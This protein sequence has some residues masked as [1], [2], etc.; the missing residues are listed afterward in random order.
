MGIKKSANHL[1]DMPAGIAQRGISIM[2][3][4][5]LGLL[6]FFSLK[7][8]SAESSY[9][10]QD[11]EKI[12]AII[13]PAAY[14]CGMGNTDFVNILSELYY[15]LRFESVGH[16]TLGS[17]LKFYATLGEAKAH[18]GH[19]IPDDQLIAYTKKKSQKAIIELITEKGNI[20]TINA[21]Y[22]IT[23][24]KRFSKIV[25]H[26]DDSEFLPFHRPQW[27][28]NAI[29]DSDQT[30]GALAEINRQYMQRLR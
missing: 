23:K 15:F 19:E 12:Y 5:V 20:I 16:Y 26:D 14:Y 1:S 24:Y 28:K 2:N 22:S 18:F 30:L 8:V 10:E 7:S 25:D 6:L 13:Q 17:K 4:I 9:S 11:Q 21:I 27:K 3:K 29:T